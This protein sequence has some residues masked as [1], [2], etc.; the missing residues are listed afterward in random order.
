M[1]THTCSLTLLEMTELQERP[2]VTALSSAATWKHL[3]RRCEEASALICV[4]E[5]D[6]ATRPGG[7]RPGRTVPIPAQMFTLL[8]THFTWSAHFLLLFLII[9]LVL[10]RRGGAAFTAFTRSRRRWPLESGSTHLGEHQ[11][12]GRRRERRRQNPPVSHS[13]QYLSRL[14]RSFP[15]L[16]SVLGGILN[17]GR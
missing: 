16:W 14:R 2:Q 1:T 3:Q 6:D 9:G 8:Q 10:L 15:P 5:G 4:R 11:I 17:G 7:R 13:V 12:R